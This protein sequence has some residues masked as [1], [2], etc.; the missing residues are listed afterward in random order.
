LED[1]EALIPLSVYLN[2]GLN[3]SLNAKYFITRPQHQ[4]GFEMPKVFLGNPTV[5][6]LTVNQAE[7][8][9]RIVTF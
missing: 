2:A 6:D 4:I 5:A 3:S 8:P 1:I 7:Q 9:G